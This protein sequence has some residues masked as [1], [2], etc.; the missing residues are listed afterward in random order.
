MMDETTNPNDPMMTPD[1][2]APEAPAADP[3]AVPTPEA[4]EGDAP[5]V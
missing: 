1:Q 5:A 4:P 2:T 3:M